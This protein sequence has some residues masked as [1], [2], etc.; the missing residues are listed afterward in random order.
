MPILSIVIPTRERADKLRYT[1]R[2]VV[3]QECDELQIVVCDNYS[4]DNTKE[5]VDSF[6]DSR[7]TYLNTG[8]RLSMCDNW[9]YAFRAVTGAYVIYLGDDDGLMPGAALTLLE[10]IRVKP[11]AVYCW[12]SHEYVW[13]TSETSPRINLIATP[14]APREIDL[15][16]A[17]A[18][19]IKW[20]GFRDHRLP[21]VYYSAVRVD[22]L[23]SIC[24]QTGRIFHS[25]A[26]DLFT[27]YALPVFVPKA[28]Y[29]GR[30]L[31]VIGSSP[32]QVG[33]VQR[34]FDEYPGYE[35]H[36]SLFPEAPLMVKHM[37]DSVLVAMDL[38]P[39]FYSRLTFNYEAMWANMIW[40]GRYQRSLTRPESRV[41][42]ILHLFSKSRL[43]RMRH[44]FHVIKFLCYFTLGGVIR[45]RG[46]IKA[47][48]RKK[49]GAA[50]QAPLNI[51]DFI[52]LVSSESRRG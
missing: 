14:T 42:S 9:D 2:T 3:D 30:P 36:R 52:T 37:Q 15:H 51:I 18:F 43:V 28:V 46:N 41:A 39:T 11:A 4:Q 34:F 7:I 47:F 31:T 24:L 1:L 26:P 45:A 38:F 19:S 29:L 21:N 6:R 10:A 20:G 17:V 32:K 25:Q 50:I 5:V 13:P 33:Y 40:C 44:R 22:I 12:E 8:R 23:N 27:G 16:E 35:Y 48:F 49:S